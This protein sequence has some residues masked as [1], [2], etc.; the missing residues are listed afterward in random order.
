M[1]WRGNAPPFGFSANPATWLPMPPQWSALTVERQLGAAG[2][3]LTLFRQAIEL[4]RD[5][6]EFDGAT[7]EWLACEPDALGFGLAGGLVCV[8]NASADPI[9]L[10]PGRVLLASAE[11]VDAVLP[12]NTAVWLV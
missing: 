5:R 4:R 3:P 8:L 6:V 11:L 7:V 2:S 10:P 9:P 12:P 1:P